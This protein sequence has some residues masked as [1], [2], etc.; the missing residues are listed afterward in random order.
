MPFS[1]DESTAVDRQPEFTQLDIELSFTDSDKIIALVENIL[2]YSWPKELGSLPAT[3]NRISYDEAMDRYG[4]DK[5][6][7][8]YKDLQ[9]NMRNLIRIGLF[10]ELIPNNYTFQMEN[11]TDLVETV[12][13]Q[14]T[15]YHHR[16]YIIPL[17]EKFASSFTNQIEDS[18]KSIA[19]DKK[20]VQFISTRLSDDWA[21][22]CGLT[23]AS[24]N[25]ISDKFNLEKSDVILFAQ[26]AKTDV[27]GFISLLF[28]DF[29]IIVK[30]LHFYLFS[31]F[32]NTCSKQ[33]WGKFAR[34]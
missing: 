7:M 18:L 10:A 31:H 3:F 15:D 22:K 1:R 2:Q 23:E 14:Q 5:P 13:E 25:A 9:V 6:D 17:Q 28:V 32:F 27:V 19:V 29:G 33:F 24:A 8:R 30:I 11:V 34:S 16:T 21:T 20:H 12:G 4:S 26:G